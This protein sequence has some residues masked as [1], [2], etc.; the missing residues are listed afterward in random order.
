VQAATDQET[1]VVKGVNIVL[2]W[3]LNTPTCEVTPRF[4]HKPCRAPSA[5]QWRSIASISR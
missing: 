2:F 5:R 3:S 4:A 1:H